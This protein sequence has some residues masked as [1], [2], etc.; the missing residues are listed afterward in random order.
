MRERNVW[1]RT[2]KIYLNFNGYKT[3]LIL[4]I[5]MIIYIFLSNFVA[6]EGNKM[7]GKEFKQLRRY[8]EYTQ[9]QVADYCNVNKSTISK[10][11][12][13]KL[14]ISDCLLSKIVKFTEEKL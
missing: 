1:N 10:W 11:E 3:H 12:N 5:W 8:Q 9:Q 14:Q 6:K 2:L 4:A 13:D 7:E